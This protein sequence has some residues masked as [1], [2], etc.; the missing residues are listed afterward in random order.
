ML[1]QQGLGDDG[2][3]AAGSEQL[4]SGDQQVDNEKEEFA[5]GVKRIMVVGLRKAV[6]QEV[7]SNILGI[8][9]PQPP[10]RHHHVDR[11]ENEDLTNDANEVEQKH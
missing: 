5:H 6:P 2:A 8:R 1:Q 3:Q 9:H 10:Y 4:R 11:R 7:N